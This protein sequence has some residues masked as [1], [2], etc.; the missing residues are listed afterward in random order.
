M[1]RKA[2]NQI[3]EAGRGCDLES[4][5][6]MGEGGRRAMHPTDLFTGVSRGANPRLTLS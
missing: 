4:R 1:S 5:S 3:D 6:A 2:G